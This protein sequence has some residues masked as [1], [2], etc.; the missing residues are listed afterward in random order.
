MLV[1]VYLVLVVN[2]LAYLRTREDV[3][4]YR[5]EFPWKHPVWRTPKLVELK[6][7]QGSFCVHRRAV[8][9][10]LQ[11]GTPQKLG[12]ASRR[13]STNLHTSVDVWRRLMIIREMSVI[14]ILE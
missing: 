10:R 2:C 9:A 14:L 5:V 7:R 3:R 1:I 11:S 13:Q 8:S 12:L 6:A 4:L